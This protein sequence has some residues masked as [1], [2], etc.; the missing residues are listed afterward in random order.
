MTK[1]FYLI[2]DSETTNADMVYDFG[3][4]V[5]DRK[6]NIL[7]SCAVIVAEQMEAELF[8]DIKDNG[9]WGK[10]AATE[11]KAKYANM[12]S[13][14]SRMVASVAAINRWLEKVCGKYNPMLTAYNIAFDNGK[15]ANTGIDLSMFSK[16]FCLWHLAATM[17]C[18]T[19]AYK[20]FALENHYFGNRTKFGNM[21][22]KTNAECVAHYITGNDITE[23]HTAKEDAQ[24][25]EMPILLSLVNR[26]GWKKNIG[27]PYNWKSFQLKDH[28]KA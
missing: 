12:L 23:P 17:V 15:C 26:K 20:K 22:I 28:Y 1:E 8:Y 13:Q 16:Q 2:V 25:F 10:K 27:L 3:A 21:T 18:T 4:V 19:K 9:I 14:G 7:T 6:G 11:R 24:F 5:C